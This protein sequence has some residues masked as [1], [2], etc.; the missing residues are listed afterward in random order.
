MTDTELQQQRAQ[1]WHTD[2]NAVRTLEDA[3]SFLESVGFCLMFPERSLPLFPT[4]MGAYG[5]SANGLPDAKHAFSD[6]RTQPAVDLMVRL[7]RERDAYEMSLFAGAALVVSS[8]LFPFFYALVGDR[9][10][11]AAPK[12]RTQGATV[13]PLA[14]T[15]FQAIQ[16]KGPL[17]KGTLRELVGREPSNAALDRSLSE[18]WAIL[19]ITRVD[20]RHNEGAFWDVLYRWSPEVVKEGINISAAEAISA[21]LSKYLESAVAATQDEIEQFF[22]YLTSRSKVREA[23]HALL[24]AR[25][26]SYMTVGA[27]TMIRLTP[28]PEPHSHPSTRNPRVPGTPRRNKHE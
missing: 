13:S 19:K 1:T 26:L 3:R 8:T 5:G 25:E 12:V 23:I 14:T 20:Y 15:V 17:S 21:V 22:S 2:G 7:L 4:W 27:K 10:P 6:P 28:L 24:A 16:Q 18:L 9:N 11:K